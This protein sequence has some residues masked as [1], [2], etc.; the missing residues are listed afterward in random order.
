MLAFWKEALH[1]IPREPAD[2]GWVVLCDSEGRGPNVAVRCGSIQ[3]SLRSSHN[4]LF[5][6]VQALSLNGVGSS[7]RYEKLQKNF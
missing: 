5:R 7:N 3:A 6:Q 1:Y 4:T 2:D